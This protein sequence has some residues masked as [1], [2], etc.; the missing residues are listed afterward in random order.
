MGLAIV[1]ESAM[2]VTAYFPHLGHTYDDYLDALSDEVKKASPDLLLL[3]TYQ[4]LRDFVEDYRAGQQKGDSDEKDGKGYRNMEPAA[5]SH[6][7]FDGREARLAT[8]GGNRHDKRFDKD[9][10]T[11]DPHGWDGTTG[12]ISVSS[13]DSRLVIDPV[14]IDFTTSLRKL[15]TSHNETVNTSNNRGSIDNMLR[16]FTSKKADQA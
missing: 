5:E 14:N 10:S 9:F 3:A 11:N 16:C 13:T 4:N 8:S 6:V 2:D 7:G 1:E 15:D 12:N